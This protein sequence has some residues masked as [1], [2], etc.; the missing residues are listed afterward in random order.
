MDSLSQCARHGAAIKVICRRCQ[1]ER[2]FDP[3]ALKDWLG[4][5]EPDIS[6]IEFRCR[7]GS[8]QVDSFAQRGVPHYSK[9]PLPSRPRRRDDLDLP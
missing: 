9:S 3:A 7:C 5:G 8:R 1:N 6:T 2:C 4:R